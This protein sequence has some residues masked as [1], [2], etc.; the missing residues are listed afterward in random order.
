MD[1]ETDEAVAI[2]ISRGLRDDLPALDEGELAYTTDT[3]ELWIGTETG[4]VCL[5][6]SGQTT[7]KIKRGDLARLP[8]L[9][10][11]ELAFTKDTRELWIGTGGGNVKLAP[12]PGPRGERGERG[13]DGTA[14]KDGPEGAQ[15]EPGVTEIRKTTIRRG[16][17]LRREIPIGT[18]AN[19]GMVLS[20]VGV[21]SATPFETQ[22]V[23]QSGG[24]GPTGT[25]T[26]GTFP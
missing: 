5:T 3:Q 14:G 22:W 12:V 6:E 7:L 25:Y 4:N 9:A 13:S 18:A 20:Y 10:D 16:G 15:G 19:V 21:H 24:S 17:Q 23:A 2:R 8:Q 1:E 11:G 26:T